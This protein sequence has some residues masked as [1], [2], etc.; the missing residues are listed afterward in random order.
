MRCNRTLTSWA[1]AHFE[2]IVQKNI[3]SPF[4]A[5]RDFDFVIDMLRTQSV[6]WCIEMAAV[7]FLIY[8]PTIHRRE[9]SDACEM[10]HGKKKQ[11]KIKQLHYNPDVKE[12]NEKEYRKKCDNAVDKRNRKAT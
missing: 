12:S 9:L 6:Q 10:K 1:L 11:E 2:T 5:D 7:L 4:A 3:T 8:A